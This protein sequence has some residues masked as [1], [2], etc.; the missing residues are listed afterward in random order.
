M[1]LFGSPSIA[2]AQSL[3]YSTSTQEAITEA[4]AAHW[5]V[6]STLMEDIVMCE[7]NDDPK[8]LGDHSHSRGLVQISNIYHPEITDKEAY[9][10][11][12]AL[13]FLAKAL[14]EGKGRQW[15]C[16]RKLGVQ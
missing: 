11:L 9:D 5:G 10:P 12:F 3:T 6:S 4:I 2:H 7:S 14:S 13:N 8:A 15:T 16:A 1:L